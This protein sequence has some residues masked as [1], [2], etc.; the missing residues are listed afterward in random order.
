MTVALIKKPK[1]GGSPPM[2]IK[3]RTRK[4]VRIGLL[5]I[6]VEIKIEFRFRRITLRIV[7]EI[8]RR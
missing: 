6:F 8:M 7:V 5:S 1:N 4:S 2:F 3:D